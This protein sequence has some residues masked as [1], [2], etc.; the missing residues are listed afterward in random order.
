MGTPPQDYSNI[1]PE[2]DCLED[3]FPFPGVYSRVPFNL[4]GWNPFRS[5]WGSSLYSMKCWSPREMLITNCK[6]GDQ[7]QT[8]GN[9]LYI[10]H[11]STTYP[12]L[13]SSSSIFKPFIMFLHL[14]S[15]IKKS[16]LKLTARPWKL[17]VG[18]GFFAFGCPWLPQDQGRK[19]WKS[20]DIIPNLYPSRYF[21][22]RILPIGSMGIHGM[23]T[24]MFRWCLC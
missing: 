6:L 1:E 4:L 11:L 23:F 14:S 7:S 22:S 10:E 9:G 24:H 15:Y 5:E 2:N 19:R 12:V 3:D 16:S 13:H 20:D 21:K 8:L 17:M 18:R